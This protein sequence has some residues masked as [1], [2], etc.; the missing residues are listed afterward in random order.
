MT[1]QSTT[2]T[3][4]LLR[5]ENLQTAFTTERGVLRAV[6]GV[7][8][9]LNRGETLGIVGESGSG[10][11]VL[12]RTIMGLT[13]NS[14]STRVTGTVSFDGRDVHAMSSAEHR[15]LWGPRVAMVFQD[16]MTALNPF[17]RIGVHLTESLKVH[18][19]LRKAE[20]RSR[21]TELLR[22]VGIPDPA[23]RL[24]QYPHEL[25]GGMRQRVVIAMA[26]ACDP[27][28][29]IADEPTTALDVT[30]QKQI[31][32]LLESLNDELGMG[33]I[34][35]SHDLGVVAGRA[36]R[37]A[38]M[39]AGKVVETA[40]AGEVFNHP[41][42]PY[43]EA[44]LASIP[45]LEQ[46]AHTRLATIGGGLPDM[47]RPMPGCRFAARCRYAQPTCLEKEPDLLPSPTVDAAATP[48]SHACF[49]PVGTP[50]GEQALSANA[51]AGTT[52]AGRELA[53]PE[54]VA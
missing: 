48:H 29:L 3:E 5:V 25:S 36:D 10:K 40:A 32:D 39:Y 11:S 16:P 38:V 46:P 2:A 4:P 49:F 8:L 22:K 21:A 7:S 43:T 20:A 31:L 44:L 53:R 41:R 37:V 51:A 45:R 13:S 26:L 18:L 1:T 33:V 47:T 54:V 6:D 50:E 15:R 23:R 24:D 17:K 35:I 28:L 42:H 52:A 9:T 27:E 30:V 14:G 12:G 19:G 34:L